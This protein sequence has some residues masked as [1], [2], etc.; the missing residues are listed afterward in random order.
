MNGILKKYFLLLFVL[1][2]SLSAGGKNEPT[3]LDSLIHEGTQSLV[4]AQQHNAEK[5]NFTPRYTIVLDAKKWLSDLPDNSAFYPSLQ[6]N[7][8]Y[9]EKGVV[10]K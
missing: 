7:Q 4:A 9:Y 5:A 10:F 6:P 2:C 1:V 8:W 3:W